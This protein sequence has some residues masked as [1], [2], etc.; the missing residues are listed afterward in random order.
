MLGPAGIVVSHLPFEVGGVADDAG[1]GPEIR[2]ESLALP[3][4]LD[5]VDLARRHFRIELA[6]DGAMQVRS[7]EGRVGCLVNQTRISCDDRPEEP[8]VAPLSAGDNKIVAG[9]ARSAARFTLRLRR[10]TSSAA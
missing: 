4:G 9:G 7:L 2:R 5:G 10:F 8:D 3:G 1:S 6:H